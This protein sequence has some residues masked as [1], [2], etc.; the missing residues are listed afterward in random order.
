MA[1]YFGNKLHVSIFG[2]SHGNGIGAVV[3]GLP[4]GVHIDM[5]ELMQFMRRRQGGNNAMST[6][7]K[8]PDVPEFVSGLLDECTNGF[9]LCIR[10][11]NTNKRSSD[12]NDL[13]DMPRPSHADFTA[14]TKW[15]G[16][17]DMRGGGHFSGRLTAPICAAGGIAKQILA[18]HGVHIGAHLLS[19]HGVQDDLFPMVPTADLFREVAEKAF[20][21]L[22][23]FAGEQMKLEILAARESLDSVG[24]KIECMI[25]GF[26]AG[27]GDPMFGGIENELA[28]VLFGIPAVK[29][30]EF[31]GGFAMCDK[32]GS[33]VNDPFCVVNNV[34]TTESN[35][36]GGIQGGISNGMP[37]RF[38]VGIK[39]TP[40]ISQ[41]QKTVSL[42]KNVNTTLE[43]HGRHDP[44]IAQRAVPVI[45]AAAALVALDFLLSDGRNL[46]DIAVHSDDK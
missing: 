30:V 33:E 16:D 37:I 29:G 1:S 45:E 4:A 5:D 38:C 28:R 23:D 43:I 24:G 27:V 18:Q 31:G 32:K 6:A 39:P 41:P 14:Y 20:P 8:E 7:R 26:P 36:S 44:C 10:I 2:E 46:S 17:A 42:S 21:V 15:H 12:Y 22:N 13:A 9:P 35:Y 11:A 40:S 19:V 25:T 34:I 3:D